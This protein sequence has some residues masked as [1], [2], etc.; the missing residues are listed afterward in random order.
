MRF[1]L[2]AA[3]VVVAAGAVGWAQAATISFGSDSNPNGPTFNGFSGDPPIR[4]LDGGLVDPDGIVVVDLLIDADENGPGLPTVEEAGFFFDG[5]LTGYSREM[6]GTAWRHE[7]LVSGALMFHHHASG[8]MLLGVEFDNALMTSWSASEFDM[9]L[10]AT[11]QWNALVDA[12]PGPFEGML[13]EGF[14]D[15]QDFA[16]TLTDIEVF[17]EFGLQV[18]VGND[19]S[20]RADWASEGSFSATLVPTP[21]AMGLLVLGGLV[22]GRRRR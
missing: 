13:V 21:G 12:A 2:S 7:W 19:G 1:V 17:G 4:L 5:T 6:V 16:F 15:V 20:F 9:G 18:P 8:E 3:A 11:L 14:G 22:A 10:S